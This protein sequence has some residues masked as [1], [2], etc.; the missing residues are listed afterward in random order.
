[1][2]IGFFLQGAE[3]SGTSKCDGICYKNAL[4]DEGV[5]N[6]KSLKIRTAIS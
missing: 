5:Y 3:L 2:S 6:N 4:D 1:M